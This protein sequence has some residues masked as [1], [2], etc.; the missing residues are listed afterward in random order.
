MKSRSFLTRRLRL[1]SARTQRRLIF[2]L[3]GIV[4]GG[5]A[6]ALALLADQAQAAFS[7][8][9]THWQY[10]SLVTM[11]LGLGLSAWLTRRVFPE[12]PRQRHTASH[13]RPAFA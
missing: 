12:L 3:G 4:V 13:R 10:A 6:V 7:R 2:L 5:A 11:P 9:I 1:H 8:V